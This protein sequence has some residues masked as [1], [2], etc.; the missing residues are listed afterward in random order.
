[1]PKKKLL[2]V[3]PM[4]GMHPQI[5]LMAAMLEDGTREWREEI[6]EVPDEAVAWQP[7]PGGHSIGAEILHIAEV[8]VWWI[9]VTTAGK[10]I[11]EAEWKELRSKEIQQYKG[12]WPDLKP[13]PVAGLYAI[14]DRIR[15]RT[16]ETLKTL[17]EVESRRTR[18]KWDIE[19][20][21]RWILAHVVQHESYH[22]G[23][24]VLLKMMWDR[25]NGAA[26]S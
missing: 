23:Q 1:M 12:Q 9:E 14:H 4:E 5:G 24:A 3:A 15:A 8:E 6:G 11:S 13:Q 26:D 21:V 18:S 25:L 19:V 20:T 2:D 22:G 17:N 10:E 16:L 7:H